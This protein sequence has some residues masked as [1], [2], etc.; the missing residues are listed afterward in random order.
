M[1]MSD[2][3]NDSNFDLF[4]VKLVESNIILFMFWSQNQ[5]NFTLFEIFY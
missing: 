2:K 4:G 1:E 3:E 5:M